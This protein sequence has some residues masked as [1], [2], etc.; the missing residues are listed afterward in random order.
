MA[1]QQHP[2]RTAAS[3]VFIHHLRCLLAVVGMGIYVDG[4]SCHRI[5]CGNSAP[6]IGMLDLSNVESGSVAVL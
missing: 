1:H 6:S 3:E 4:I 2:T 5:P